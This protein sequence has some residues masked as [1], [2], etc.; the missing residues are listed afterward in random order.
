MCTRPHPEA[1]AAA[2]LDGPAY[3]P[4]SHHMLPAGGNRKQFVVVTV[5]LAR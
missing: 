2:R 1:H 5:L 4:A 3:Y